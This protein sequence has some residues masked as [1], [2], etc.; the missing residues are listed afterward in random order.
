VRFYGQRWLK[1]AFAG[2][3]TASSGPTTNSAQVP[4]RVAV[5]GQLACPIDF[6]RIKDKGRTSS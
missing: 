3:S 5:R 6:A 1:R 2:V 4:Q